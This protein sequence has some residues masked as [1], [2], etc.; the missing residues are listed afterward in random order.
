MVGVVREK[1]TEELVFKFRSR[2]Y[3]MLKNNLNI[4]LYYRVAINIVKQ[5]AGSVFQYRNHI[6]RIPNNII[7]HH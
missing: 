7:A 6:H 4:E 2:R 5:A 1:D 3:Y